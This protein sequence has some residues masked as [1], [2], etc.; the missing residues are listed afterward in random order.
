MGTPTEEFI[1]LLR[2][3][4]VSNGEYTQEARRLINKAAE[5]GMIVYVSKDSNLIQ[6]EF[7]RE[8]ILTLKQSKKG[9]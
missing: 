7:P 1:K 3:M 8:R 9:K 6:G 4:S 2:K 5:E